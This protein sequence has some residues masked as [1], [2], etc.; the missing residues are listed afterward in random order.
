M[1]LF[2]GIHINAIHDPSTTAADFLWHCTFKFHQ[3]R[4]QFG[5]AYVR[6]PLVLCT[7]C[8][9]SN[10]G[11]A[12][13]SQPEYSLEPF[14]YPAGRLASLH[15]QLQLLDCNHVPSLPHPCLF[16]IPT[17]SR[18]GM[19][20]WAALA[21][22]RTSSF[23]ADSAPANHFWDG[24]QAGG[25]RSW[26]ELMVGSSHLWCAFMSLYVA[27]TPVQKGNCAYETY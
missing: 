24:I 8:P 12:M 1:A 15:C 27:S 21:T 6:T 9:A 18:A 20:A 19:V 2:L 17:S 10:V 4:T 7:P 23:E 22:G 5:K 16:S 13:R 11:C 14:G 3:E 26:H 25:G